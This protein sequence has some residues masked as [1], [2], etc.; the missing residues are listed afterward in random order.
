MW[1]R[2]ASRRVKIDNDVR[3]ARNDA[4]PYAFQSQGGAVAADARGGRGPWCWSHATSDA[5][6]SSSPRHQ[7]PQLDAAYSRRPGCRTR[8]V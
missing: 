5:S 1:S 2:A 3:S 8:Q 7:R 6:S 4:V